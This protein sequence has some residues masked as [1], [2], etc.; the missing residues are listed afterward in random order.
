MRTLLPQSLKI[1]RV[2]SHDDGTIGHISICCFSFTLVAKTRAMSFSKKSIFKRS[3]IVILTEHF[4]QITYPPFFFKMIFMNFYLTVKNWQRIKMHILALEN[5]AH[6]NLSP[7]QIIKAIQPLGLMDTTICMLLIEVGFW[8]LSQEHMEQIVE[9]ST[10]NPDKKKDEILKDLIERGSIP[11]ESPNEQDLLSA[12]CA[13]QVTPEQEMNE[14][15]FSTILKIMNDTND[16]IQGLDE[17][18]KVGFVTDAEYC[19][20]KEVAQKGMNASIA[21]LIDFGTFKTLNEVGFWG[22]TFDTIMNIK[23][24]I[25]QYDCKVAESTD[26]TSLQCDFILKIRDKFTEIQRNK[27]LLKIYGA[28]STLKFQC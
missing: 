12:F 19:V 7:R 4:K 9:Q 6:E 2:H 22:L 21:E 5:L 28:W 8:V 11:K 17:Q 16:L 23:D 1:A 25:D 20:M 14:A 18:L 3:T 27:P 10:K 26:L 15:K 24:A 13:W